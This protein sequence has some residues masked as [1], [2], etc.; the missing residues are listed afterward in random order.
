MLT[1][2]R[3]ALGVMATRTAVEIKIRRTG[4]IRDS[5]EEADAIAQPMSSRFRGNNYSWYDNRQNEDLF[6]EFLRIPKST[7]HILHRMMW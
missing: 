1:Q 6:N 2:F 7:S 3:R 5:I 4:F